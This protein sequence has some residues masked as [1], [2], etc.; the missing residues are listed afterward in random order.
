MRQGAR[1]ELLRDNLGH[2]NVD[3]TQNVYGESWWEERVE[4]GGGRRGRQFPAKELTDTF[5][6][7]PCSPLR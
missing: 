5:H 6:G 1:C 3:V 2:A 4:K 7:F